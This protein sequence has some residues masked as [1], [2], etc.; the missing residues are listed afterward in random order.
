M[1]ILLKPPTSR[2]KKTLLML[3]CNGL[4][5]DQLDCNKLDN[6]RLDDQQSEFNLSISFGKVS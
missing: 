3:D 4:D 6:D 5:S 1:C 2:K